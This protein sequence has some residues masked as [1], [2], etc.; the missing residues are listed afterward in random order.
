MHYKGQRMPFKDIDGGLK[1]L[2]RAAYHECLRR[3]F[4]KLPADRQKLMLEQQTPV[5]KNTFRDELDYYDPEVSPFVHDVNF[6][7]SQI[8]DAYQQDLWLD[9]EPDQSTTDIPEKA[10][11][12]VR[13]HRG[14]TQ[15]EM[16]IEIIDAV[17]RLY[18]NCF[19]GQPSL[20]N[21]EPIGCTIK[22]TYP[23]RNAILYFDKLIDEYS[24]AKAAL[25]KERLSSFEESAAIFE[26]LGWNIEAQRMR[27]K[28]MVASMLVGQEKEI[29]RLRDIVHMPAGGPKGLDDH[30]P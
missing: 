9:G 24:Q 28:K 10:R 14:L 15:G 6:W 16:N 27:Q 22:M 20:V 5:G 12:M 19:S 17:N 8:L 21:M 2:A 23:D 11:A 25:L 30:G 1:S 26:N 7:I 13:N 3:A 4:S 18:N 29:S